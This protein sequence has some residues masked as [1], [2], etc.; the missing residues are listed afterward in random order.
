M[1][2]W[3]RFWDF[4]NVIGELGQLGVTICPGCAARISPPVEISP[5]GLAYH[6]PCYRVC[7]GCNTVMQRDDQ[8][9]QFTC[10]NA[11]CAEM[12]A[13]AR[14]LPYQIGRIAYQHQAELLA[15]QKG[16]NLSAQAAVDAQIAT[17]RKTLAY[18]DARLI[19]E[20]RRTASSIRYAGDDERR[21]RLWSQSL[22]CE[23]GRI[24]LE[25]GAELARYDARRRNFTDIWG[26][27][28]DQFCHDRKAMRALINLWKRLAAAHERKRGRLLNA[29]MIGAEDADATD[30]RFAQLEID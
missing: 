18:A 20:V 15:K 19:E 10:R 5:A 3:L 27:I 8:D 22:S 29:D 1:A 9:G 11:V 24:G 28:Q 30:L 2:D 4:L 16:I 7:L 13:W 14:D 21:C 6:R 26:S 17:A 25:H 23:W 12:H